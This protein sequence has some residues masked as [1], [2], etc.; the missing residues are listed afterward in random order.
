MDAET[1]QYAPELVRDNSAIAPPGSYQTGYHLTE[2]L[3]DQAH[4]L[5]RRSHRGDGPTSP[6]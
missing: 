1:D 3:I 6:G 5:H 4:P 2:D